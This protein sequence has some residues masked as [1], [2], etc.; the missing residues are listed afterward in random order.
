MISV[1][2]PT[3]KRA[4]KI[5]AAICSA[6][7]QTYKDVEI[8][9]VSDGTDTATD[10]V[11][12]KFKKNPNIKYI[13]Y[14][15]NKGG[16][17]ARNIGIKNAKGELIAFLDDDDS[18]I[19]E[20]LEKQVSKFNDDS[21]VGLVYTGHSQVYL[22]TNINLVYK[23]SIYGD[24]SKKIFEK[25]YIGS[26]SSVVVKKNILE[27]AGLFDESLPAMQDYDLWIRVAQITQIGVI[28]E[29]LLIYKN[30]LKEKQISSNIYKQT[31][32][33]S[34]IE[35]KYHEFFQK[36]KE[37]LQIFEERYYK[38]IIKISKKNGDKENFAKYSREF[39]LNYPTIKNKMYCL[40]FK[41]P[42]KFILK[43]TEILRFIKNLL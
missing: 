30:D 18:W 23:P 32:A 38:N 13:S 19:P 16:N 28:T 3:Y 5:E 15:K 26:T 27:K 24:L 36:N 37:Y 6:L 31:K 42:Y 20:K 43:H 25:N 9:V 12:E 7:N 33:K 14:E 2:I 39:I 41:M 10:R 40:I 1:I 35:K 11:M 8:I 29:P 34:V 4:N 21:K 17:Y 22:G